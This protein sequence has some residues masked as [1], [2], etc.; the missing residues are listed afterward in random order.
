MHSIGMNATHMIA[1]A[2]T[3]TASATSPSETAR[4]YAGAVDATPITMFDRYPN[5]PVL[6]PLVP[7][8]PSG[9]AVAAVIRVLLLGTPV[10]SQRGGASTSRAAWHRCPGPRD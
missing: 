6:R 3:P 2:W 10:R 7:G 9:A 1:G 4:L 8:A 5:A